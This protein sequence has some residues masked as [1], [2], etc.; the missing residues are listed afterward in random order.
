MSLDYIN[1]AFK[2]LQR[3]DEAAFDPSFNGIRDL[4][5]FMDKDNVDDFVKVIDPDAE[6][7]DDIQDS[8]IGKVITTCNICHSHIF[9]NKEDIVLDEDGNVNLETQCPYCG[10][11]EGFTVV[12]EIAEF[13]PASD[14]NDEQPEEVEVQVDN[15]EVPVEETPVVEESVEEDKDDKEETLTESMNNVN[16]ET[17]DTIVSVQSDENG[18]VTVSTEPKKEE[19]PASDDEMIQPLSDETM[20][21]IESNNDITE[22]VED[23][24]EEAPEEDDGMD[25]IDFDDFDEESFDE[26]GESY[27]KRVYENVDSFKTSDVSTNDTQL[28]VEGVI[29]FK[30]GAEKKTGFLFE[31]NGCGTNGRVAFSGMNEHFSR[32]KKSFLLHGRV[33]N[34]KLVAESLTYNYRAKTPEG[35]PSKVYGTV[36]RNR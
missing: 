16:V 23:S 12:G 14:D 24:F 11:Q 31:A 20:T 26:L 1:E 25:D 6:L 8:Y 18:K 17:D 30:S 4:K 9:N 32:G 36:S 2:T 28:I 27:M 35:K 19:A 13:V 10:E 29:R 15:E 7:E 22:P 3:L 5:S 33:N 21:D 34:K